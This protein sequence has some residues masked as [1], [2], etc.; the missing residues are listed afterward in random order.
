MSVTAP[1]VHLNGTS[2][3]QLVDDYTEAA[4]YARSLLEKLG[5]TSPNMRDYYP[6]GKE[7]YDKA[8]AE[9]SARVNR[10]RGVL[11]ELEQLLEAVVTQGVA[12]GP[13]RVS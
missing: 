5:D 8:F 1:V 10:V 6:I 3:Q 12:V 7:A 13:V 11:E 9:H 4:S 2:R